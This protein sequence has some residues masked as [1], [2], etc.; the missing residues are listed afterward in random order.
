[1]VSSASQLRVLATWNL[2][3]LRSRVHQFANRSPLVVGTLL[4]F[5]VAYLVA[6]YFLFS[7]GL[8]HIHR[9]P[10]VGSLL[11]ERVLYLIFFFVFIMLALSNA[12]VQYG[13]LFTSAQTKWLMTL[14]IRR[15]NLL[16]WKIT[17]SLVISS[18]GFMF[19]SA[20]LLAAYGALHEAPWHFYLK[21]F[22]LILPFVAVPAAV[23]SW[24]LLFLARFARKS[25]FL[26]GF[27]I[28]LP[29][30][31]V[32]LWREFGAPVVEQSSGGNIVLALNRAMRHTQISIHPLMPSTWW[33]DAL[34][35]WVKGLQGAAL[36]NALLLLSNYTLA[37]H[38]LWRLDWTSQSLHTLSDEATVTVKE[39]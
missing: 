12:A 32:Y 9:L 20:P 31:A 25:W 34:I 15:R 16:F 38:D 28:L 10:A 29:I 23:A 33:T 26:V 27:G 19:L 6:G 7:I 1:M 17:E 3:I 2:R 22:L 37:R 13:A 24:L 11:G 5:L 39:L 14:P 35:Q 18:W 21:A 8:T 36:F 4:F 30:G